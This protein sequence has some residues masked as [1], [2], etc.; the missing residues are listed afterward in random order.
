MIRTKHIALAL[1]FGVAAT[2]LQAQDLR[3][4]LQEDPDVLDP[5]Q[6]RTFV[7]RIV[8]ASMCDKLVDITPGLEI[9]PQLATGW[10]WSDDGL[11]LTMTLREGVVFHDGTAFNAEAVAAN[12]D[13]SQNLP[14]SR[15]K[16]ELGSITGV[17]VVDDYTITFTLGA[18]D[19]TLLA[20]FADRAGMMLS[21]TAFEAAGTDFGLNPVCSGPFSF[22]ER[23]QQ[24]RIVLDRFA[25]YWNADAI[26]VDSVTF[27][28]MPDTTVRLANLRAGDLDMLERLAATDVASVQADD[29][30]T[31]EQAV[32]LGYQGIT[33]NVANGAGADNPLGQD[34]RIRQALSLSIDR[35]VINQVV[36][37]GAFAPGNQPFPPTS[38]WYN[39]A[40]PV[41]ER[42]VE[43]ARALLAEA[44]FA[45]GID[46]TVQVP[47]NPVQLQMMQVVQAMASEAGINIEL[48][49]KEFATLLADQSAGDY[50]A[51]QVGWSGRVDPD[52]NIHQFMTTD[53]GINDSAYSNP[54]VDRLLNEARTSTDTDVRLASYNAARDILIEDTPIIYLYHVTW[55]WALDD[56]VQGFVPYPDGMI[57][58]EGVTL[59]E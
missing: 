7:G 46:I 47:N 34:E 31:M 3:I 17:E 30:L 26:N 18:P 11:Q 53:G 27:L 19:A 39:D 35:N 29:S 1:A 44:G 37:E 25:D 33:I 21:P 5:D 12:I 22:V 2:A 45:D 23:I 15:R 20:Q 42:D 56:A 51:S 8:Y 9:I 28:P 38:P 40:Y 50:Q 41:P 6:S 13:R 48:Q 59:A 54:E 57:R 36:F 55:I 14:E 52:G 10:E 16:S 49:A 24:D 43:A 4:G 58:L 32:S